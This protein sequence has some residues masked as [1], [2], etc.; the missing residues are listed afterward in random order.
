[1]VQEIV[2][3][4]IQGFDLSYCLA[5]TILTYL[6][7]KVLNGFGKTPGTWGKRIVLLIVIAI[8]GTAYYFIGC[9]PKVL[10]NSSIL[11]PV[12]WSWI[13]KPLVKVLNIDYNK[14]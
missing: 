1:M 13:F 5:V 14:E 8:L 11:A 4:L 2:D 12:S 7:I 9:E 10:L 3:N 6:V